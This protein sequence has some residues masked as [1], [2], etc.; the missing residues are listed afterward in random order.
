[1]NKQI[2]R[3][4]VAWLFGWVWLVFV[5]WN[6]YDLV[7][8]GSMPSAL[9][10][11]AVLGVLTALV[12]LLALRP[13][14]VAEAGGV[15]VRNPLRNAY[16]PWKNV[17]DV[18]VTHA[19]IIETGHAAIRCWTPQATARERA[20]AARRAE[21]GRKPVME[22]NVSK[23]EQAAAE[24]LAGRTHADWVALQLTELS[25][26]RA[27][28]STGETKV[29]WSPYSIAALAAAAVLVVVTIVASI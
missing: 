2:F 4:K 19:I 6:V 27:A 25:V 12:F 21:R 16:V 7:A 24:L 13:A 18:I 20:K 9:I 1:M 28:D 5:V 17:G 8:H 15:R 23:G 22:A 14:I 11:G 10:A 3:S 26:S 29:T